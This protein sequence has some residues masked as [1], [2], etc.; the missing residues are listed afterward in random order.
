MKAVLI[1]YAGSYSFNVHAHLSSKAADLV[2]HTSLYMLSYAV[3]ARCEGSGETPHLCMIVWT[4]SNPN[5]TCSCV[6]AK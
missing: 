3:L 1:T 5:S 4:F 6:L 2:F